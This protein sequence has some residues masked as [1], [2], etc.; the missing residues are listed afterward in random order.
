M[1]HILVTFV[2]GLFN[3]EVRHSSRGLKNEIK[4]VMVLPFATFYDFLSSISIFSRAKMI[5]LLDSPFKPPLNI[6][7]MKRV[8][9]H[10]PPPPLKLPPPWH[11]VYLLT[12]ACD[13]LNHLCF[14][15]KIKVK[16][17]HQKAVRWCGIKATVVSTGIMNLIRLRPLRG[18]LESLTRIR[19][20][21]P[22]KPPG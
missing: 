13:Q 17:A 20:L 7:N 3:V 18:V 16:V 5:L 15:E 22:A 1:Y 14:T 9:P 2:F 4:Q 19:R 6:E 11:L 12:P 8:C 21:I 10:P